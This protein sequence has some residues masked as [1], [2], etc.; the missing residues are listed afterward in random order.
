M[1]KQ[2]RRTGISGCFAFTSIFVLVLIKQKKQKVSLA[3]PSFV[4]P[5]RQ[6]GKDRRD[7]RAWKIFSPHALIPTSCLV[8]GETE[9]PDSVVSE[10][11]GLYIRKK[12]FMFQKKKWIS[13]GKHTRNEND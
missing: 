10:P 2:G 9:S 5:V 3:L 1:G 12:E 4:M 7:T 13:S 6:R 8:L 11:F